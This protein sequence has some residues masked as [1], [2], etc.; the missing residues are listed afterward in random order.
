MIT[1]NYPIHK[2]LTPHVLSLGTMTVTN[3]ITRCNNKQRGRHV[4]IKLTTSAFAEKYSQHKS[5]LQN[6]Y[7]HIVF[8]SSLLSYNLIR[9][10]LSICAN[11]TTHLCNYYFTFITLSCRK[12]RWKQKPSNK[13]NNSSF[14]KTNTALTIIS[15]AQA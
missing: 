8:L 7:P 9:G 11:I 12:V 1:D 4:S 13:G 5:I 15:L 14:D 10:T 6:C 3:S 2:C